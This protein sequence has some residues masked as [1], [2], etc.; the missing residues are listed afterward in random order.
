MIQ[1]QRSEFRSTKSLWIKPSWEG[2][3]SYLQTSKHKALGHMGGD[4]SENNQREHLF[5]LAQYASMA[6]LLRMFV[7]VWFFLRDWLGW[8]AD[9]ISARILLCKDL[10][11]CLWSK[12]DPN[13]I[14]FSFP[15]TTLERSFFNG[16]IATYCFV[17]PGSYNWTARKYI[18]LAMS[19]PHWQKRFFATTSKLKKTSILGMVG[20]SFQDEN[21]IFESN[22]S[23]G[24]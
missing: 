13:K 10:S 24:E 7:C 21:Q 15:Q 1:I 6:T 9:C 14:G 5:A 16:M 23:K 11:N 12:S 8:K 4:T 3:N 20:E 2:I 22:I 18:A 19:L 17:H